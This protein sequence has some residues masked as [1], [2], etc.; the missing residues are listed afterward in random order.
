M[1]TAMFSQLSKARQRGRRRW[2]LSLTVS[3]KPRHDTKHM[4]FAKHSHR[5]RNLESFP[6]GKQVRLDQLLLSAHRVRGVEGMRCDY[7]Q[8]SSAS[9]FDWRWFPRLHLSKPSAEVRHKQI[10]FYNFR[11]KQ[12]LC[13]FLNNLYY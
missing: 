1:P 5:I 8:D 13:G 7:L 2:I 6:K 9:G 4:P 10:R 3:Q 11:E 12:I